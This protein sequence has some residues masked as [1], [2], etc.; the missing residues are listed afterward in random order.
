MKPGKI[1]KKLGKLFKSGSGGGKKGGS[2][3]DWPS[4]T[5]IAIYG[6]ANSG[7]T[8]YFTVLN[9]ECKFGKDLQLSITD[10]AT[11]SDI[12]SNYRAIWGV[13]TETGSGTVVDL[14]G[15]KKFPD[16][17]P[18][19]KL[20]LFNAI[21]DRDNKYSV[22]AYDYGGKAVSL[23]SSGELSEKVAD[24]TLGSDGVLFFFDPKVL[25]AEMQTHAH[26]ASFVSL[27]EKLAPLDKKLPIPVALVITKADILPG[28]SGE[29]QSILV[30]PEDES[31]LSEDFDLFLEKILSSNKIASN[32]AWSESVR[33]ILVKLR[34]FL[35]VIVG[36]TLNFQIFFVSSTGQQ[37]EKIG[38]DVGRS[39]Y[40]PPTKIKPIGIKAPFYWLLNSIVQNKRVAGFKKLARF[41]TISSILWI[42]LFSAPYLYH[43]IFMLERALKVERDVLEAYSGNI[44]NTSLKERNNVITAFRNYDKAW[45]TKNLFPRFRNPIAR[46]RSR[47]ENF[48]FDEALGR[49]D[50]TFRTFNVIVKDKKLWPNLNPS[51][52]TL[53]ETENHKKLVEALNTFHQGDENSSLY[54]RSD[55][56]LTYWDLFTRAILA[57]ND[58]TIWKTIHQQVEADNNLYA[59]DMSKD[60]KELGK[61]LK[62]QKVER[63]E[64]IVAIETAQRAGVEFD[65]VIDNVNNNMDS[66]YRFGKAIRDLRKVRGK[67]DPSNTKALS[68][69]DK[70][71]A[72]VRKWE[73]RQNFK[74]KIGSIPDQGHL[75]IEVVGKGKDPSWSEFSQIFEGDEFSFKWKLG[76]EIHIAFDSPDN[77]ETWGKDASDKKTLRG[78]VAIFE[79]DG[80]IN[81]SNIGKTISISFT[82]SLSDRIPTLE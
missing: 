22:C 41:V 31:I 45:I 52:T 32:S 54:K 48:N 53:I 13:G 18:D 25:G 59:T 27:L 79:M 33:N 63:V 80:E 16:P 3:F 12:L 69:I 2:K 61:S 75:H 65:D 50:E 78:N 55:R 35:K 9:E 47:F 60:E 28:F 38:T 34:E 7:K 73:K 39:L 37:P 1:F 30:S 23:N 74:C 42:A 43:D 82:P 49:L 57:P 77:A 26:A 64:T 56:A 62:A 81:F 40:A 68:S 14:R 20:L 58:T 66:D 72:A 11:A 46:I 67:L 44:Y 21:I 17:T 71:T 5:R 76:D 8:V 24:F 70:Y 6:H 4:G 15:E 19:G 29:E 51:D 10:T 36:R